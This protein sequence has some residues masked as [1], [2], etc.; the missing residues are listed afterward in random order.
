MLTYMTD[1]THNQTENFKI[2]CHNVLKTNFKLLKSSYP[3]IMLPAKVK[4]K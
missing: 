3:I 4:M 1:Q 2:I